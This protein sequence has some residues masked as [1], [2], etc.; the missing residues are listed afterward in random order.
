MICNILIYSVHVCE[1]TYNNKN[2]RTDEYMYFYFF[3]MSVVFLSWQN[4]ETAF[5][6]FLPYFVYSGLYISS[7]IKF[8]NVWLLTDWKSF[9]I[10]IKPCIDNFLLKHSFV[11]KLYFQNRHL[12]SKNS[13]SD[14]SANY[15]LQISWIFQKNERNVIR[16]DFLT[17]VFA[18][19]IEV[20]KSAKKQI[21]QNNLSSL[22][23]L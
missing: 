9:K 10:K 23:V 3:Y 8:S 12:S 13:F 22:L 5:L 7:V 14:P 1:H 18:Y 16:I 6:T 20:T 17:I 15:L 19:N 21:N 2:G 11:K 4:I